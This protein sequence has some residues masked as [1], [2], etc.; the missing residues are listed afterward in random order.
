MTQVGLS[1]VKSELVYPQ[2]IGQ[3]RLTVCQPEIISTV[4]RVGNQEPKSVESDTMFRM[5]LSNSKYYN[6]FIEEK[7]H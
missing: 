2:M 1:I 3:I 7:V 4:A 5:G 6:N